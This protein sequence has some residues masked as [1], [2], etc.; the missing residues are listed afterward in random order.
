VIAKDFLKLLVVIFITF[1]LIINYVNACFIINV[2]VE[3]IIAISIIVDVLLKL[4][5]L[6][7]KISQ[8]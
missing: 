4:R 7:R 2:I 5:L 3:F 1:V 8:I 6:T